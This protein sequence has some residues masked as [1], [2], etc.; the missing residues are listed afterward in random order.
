LNLCDRIRCT[1]EII[2][3]RLWR[4]GKHLHAVTDVACWLAGV[5]EFARHFHL[6]ILNINAALRRLAI[7]I[8]AKACGESS[9]Q[10]LT[11]IAHR[12]KG[13][14][15]MS[16]TSTNFYATNFELGSRKRFWRAR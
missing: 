7:N 4:I 2:D 3:D 6:Y 13:K 8:V 10:Q 14:T 12:A 1:D 9:E 11:A 16:Q 5:S 15:A